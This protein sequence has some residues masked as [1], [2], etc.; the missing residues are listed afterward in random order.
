MTKSYKKD[1]SKSSHLFSLIFGCIL[2]TSWGAFSPALA[3]VDLPNLIKKAQSSIVVIRTYTEQ[4][5]RLGQGTG[6]FI[7][8]QVD[9][10]P[11]FSIGPADPNQTPSGE[12]YGVKRWWLKIPRG[13]G[14]ISVDIPEEKSLLYRSVP[15]CP[16]WE[17]WWLSG[18]LGLDQTVSDGIVSAIRGGSGFGKLFR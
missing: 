14:K 8:K 18:P 12:E 6:F 10:Q 7:A 13:S 11:S 2:L 1:Q 17:K 15:L 16:G 3:Q 9:Y 4:G 5:T